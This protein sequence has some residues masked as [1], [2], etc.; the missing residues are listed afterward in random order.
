MKMSNLHISIPELDERN[1]SSEEF[2]RVIYVLL[3]HEMEQL[4]LLHPSKA[5]NDLTD[6]PLQ[7]AKRIVESAHTLYYVIE[8]ENDYVVAFSIIRSIADML[9]AFILI[10]GGN[11][12]EEKALRHYL[13]ILDGMK[14][15]LSLLPEKVENN[16]RLKDDEYIGFCKQI[17]DAK[18]NYGGAVDL[19]I[20]E[21]HSLQLYK[22]Y[23]K[24]IDIL[25]DRRNWKFKDVGSPKDKYKWEQMY[26]F[27]ELNL[28]GQFISS[29][30]DFVHGLSTSLLVVDIDETTF[31]PVYGVAIS[32]LG[33]LHERIGYMYKED[34]PIVRKNMLSALADEAMPEQ[35]VN[36]I[37][38]LA[39]S[40]LSKTE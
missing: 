16:G 40:K 18:L 28:D 17:N 37:L 7:L 38:C 5:I 12:I 10:Y 15:R 4:M 25:I 33:K 26:D 19:C 9:S 8:K 6:Y 20:Y 24:S 11:D 13:Y 36:Y 30:S 27:I 22:T 35:Y 23:S 31:E 34:Q 1:L 39:T 32:L 29:L 14:G 2:F 3:V 21:I